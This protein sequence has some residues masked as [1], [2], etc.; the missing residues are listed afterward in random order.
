MKR[1]FNLTNEDINLLKQI[2]DTKEIN[3]EVLDYK[4]HY[5]KVVSKPWGFEFAISLKDSHALWCLYIANNQST[6]FHCHPKKDTTLVVVRGSLECST[7]NNKY[8]LVKN[9][10]CTFH[11]GVFHSIKAI[12]DSIVIEIETSPNKNDLVRYSDNYN[13]E[14]GT[15]EG[16]SNTHSHLD[17]PQYFEYDDSDSYKYIFSDEEKMELFRETDLEESSNVWKVDKDLYMKLN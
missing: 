6:S 7:V 4:I 13:R 14:F 11:R 12:E 5:K 9:D 8:H 3:D 16:I 17:Y 1:Y 2:Y 15:Y 10:S